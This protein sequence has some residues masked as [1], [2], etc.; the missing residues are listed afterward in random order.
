MSDFAD[1]P[2]QPKFQKGDRVTYPV[3]IVEDDKQTIRE[4]TGT[5][6]HIRATVGIQQ[7]TTKTAWRKHKAGARIAPSFISFGYSVGFDGDLII[8]EVIPENMLKHANPLLR[9]AAET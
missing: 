7:P 5:V 1:W 2:V 3:I 9:L 8:S 4:L 6:R